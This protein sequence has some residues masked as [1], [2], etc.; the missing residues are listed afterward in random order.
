MSLNSFTNEHH[1]LGIMRQDIRARVPECLS[2]LSTQDRALDPHPACH[3]L[4]TALLQNISYVQKRDYSRK[5]T[6]PKCLKH[7][8]SVF[9]CKYHAKRCMETIPASVPRSANDRTMTKTPV[10]TRENILEDESED[11]Y[12]DEAIEKKMHREVRDT[13]FKMRDFKERD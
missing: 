8:P 3:L 6:Y 7:F 12:S 1:K 9:G 2:G 11:S 5:R 4:L 13:D 10:V